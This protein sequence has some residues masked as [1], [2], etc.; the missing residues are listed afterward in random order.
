MLL[1]SPTINNTSIR[2]IR[3]IQ[4]ILLDNP[5]KTIKGQSVFL[6]DSKSLMLFILVSKK[7]LG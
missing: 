2:I 7:I 6:F 3:V 4:Y 5:T 1:L